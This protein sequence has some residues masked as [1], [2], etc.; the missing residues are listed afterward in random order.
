MANDLPGKFIGLVLAFVLTVLMPF[1][2]VQVESEMMDR[3]MI[4]NHVT[5]FID[6]VIDSRNVTDAMIDDLNVSLASYGV[7][8]NYEISRYA[9]SVNAD[10]I[11]EADYYVT[12]LPQDDTTTYNKGDKISVRV[13]TVGYSS[14]G[15]LAHK[16]TG[17]FVKD[18]DETITARVR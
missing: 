5:D 4:I 2:T 15:A 16:L 12:Y 11:T 8:V 9:R 14:S 3:R 18:L 6:E 10:P 7:T 17:M 13:Y 1:V